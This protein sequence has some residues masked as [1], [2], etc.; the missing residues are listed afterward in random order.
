M[1]EHVEVYDEHDHIIVENQDG[2]VLA[3][4]PPL[5]ADK[6]EQKEHAA[7]L[8][9]QLLA[10]AGPSRWSLSGLKERLGRWCDDEVNKRQEKKKE[11]RKHEPARAYQYGNT[12]S[13]HISWSCLVPGLTQRIDHR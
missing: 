3:V 1:R 9:R 12:A 11:S 5:G 7:A 6:G 4:E 2:D 10:E 8:K 13:T